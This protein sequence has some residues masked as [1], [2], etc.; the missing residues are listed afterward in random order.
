MF[1]YY[2]FYPFY[3]FSWYSN[4]SQ[5]FWQFLNFYCFYYVFAN[6]MWFTLLFTIFIH[7]QWFSY[8]YSFLYAF[9]VLFKY[10]MQIITCRIPLAKWGPHYRGTTMELPLNY[11]WL[12]WN[13]RGTTMELLLT[14]VLGPPWYFSSDINH[15]TQTDAFVWEETQ[16]HWNILYK[17]AQQKCNQMYTKSITHTKNKQHPLKS[18][19]TYIYIKT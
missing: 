17:S 5:H 6:V 12:P 4:N 7:F 15:F 11:H 18:H 3:Y 14:T 9:V 10:F 19:Y 8:M 13:Y 2:T 1:I 16:K